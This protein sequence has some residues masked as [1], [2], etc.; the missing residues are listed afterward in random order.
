MDAQQLANLLGGAIAK[1][2]GGGRLRC[3]TCETVA[4]WTVAG[5]TAI[6]VRPAPVSQVEMGGKVVPVAVVTCRT[7]GNTKQ[8][9]LC[10]LGIVKS[11]IDMQVDKLIL[12][13]LDGTP[14]EQDGRK[15]GQAAL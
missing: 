15:D 4:N 7:C 8:F 10:A 12:S 14:V 5:Y 6:P 1:R 3:E 11:D 9:N 13:A 2:I